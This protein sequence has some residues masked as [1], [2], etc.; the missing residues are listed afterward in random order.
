M[1]NVSKPIMDGVSVTMNVVAG[2]K[3]Y[4]EA[5]CQSFHSYHK[6]WDQLFS[7]TTALFLNLTLDPL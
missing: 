2:I 7:Q 4:D 3:L 6:L 5:Y 1:H